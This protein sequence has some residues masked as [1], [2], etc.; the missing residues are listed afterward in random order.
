MENWLYFI[1]DVSLSGVLTYYLIP[2]E[3]I[4]PSIGPTDFRRL[5][6]ARLNAAQQVVPAGN[7]V[8]PLG[9]LTGKKK[10]TNSRY[11]TFTSTN[12]DFTSTDI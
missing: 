10:N 12:T 9:K 1:V 2:T 6:A 5:H 3:M 7:A 8:G 11:H 4:M